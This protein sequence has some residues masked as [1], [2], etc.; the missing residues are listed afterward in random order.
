MANHPRSRQPS[1][2]L[3][4]RNLAKPPNHQPPQQH[5]PA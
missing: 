5:H 1:R 3:P 4:R 2:T